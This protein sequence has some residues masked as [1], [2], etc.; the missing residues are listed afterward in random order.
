M[1]I[2]YI[3]IYTK[4][5]LCEL[6]AVLCLENSLSVNIKSSKGHTNAANWKCFWQYGLAR[7]FSPPLFLKLHFFDK[8]YS[9]NKK[10]VRYPYG[11]EACL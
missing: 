10:I 9:Q 2:F 1:Y 4:K 6:N 5:K 8:L 11:E 7:F 3:S